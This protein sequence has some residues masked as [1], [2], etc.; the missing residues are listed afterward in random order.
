LE[1]IQKQNGLHCC[2]FVS[3]CIYGNYNNN[4]GGANG[5][6]N[7][8]AAAN[9]N[10]ARVIWQDGHV[11]FVCKGKVYYSQG[12]KG[13]HKVKSLADYIKYVVGAK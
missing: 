9:Q 12:H 1:L 11:G 3:Y 8:G 5:W 13:E 7:W 2:Q 4:Q 10:D 6:K